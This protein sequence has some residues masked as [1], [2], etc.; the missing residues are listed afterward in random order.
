M[1]LDRTGEKEMKTLLPCIALAA[2]VL[3]AADAPSKVTYVGHDKVNAAL[4]KSA[5]LVTA[6]D[7]TV[8][9]SFRDKPG[10]VEIHD[11]ETDIMHIIEGEATLVTGGTPVGVRSTRPGQSL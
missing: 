7:L 6:T 10:Q 5:S 2:L 1:Y 9:G 4:A 3:T 11:K 8:S